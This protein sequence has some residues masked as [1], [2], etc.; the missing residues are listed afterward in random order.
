MMRNIESSL[1]K[2]VHALAAV[3][4]PGSGR[5]VLGQTLEPAVVGSNSLEDVATIVLD[6]L[7]K[8]PSTNPDIEFLKKSS[9]AHGKGRM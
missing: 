4:P 7:S 9:L 2:V 8:E 3:R 1:I 5:L 6:E